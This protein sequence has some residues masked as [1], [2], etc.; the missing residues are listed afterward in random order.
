[1]AAE[2]R[3]GSREAC[4]QAQAMIDI[5]FEHLN[6]LRT[7]CLA[8]NHITQNEIRILETKLVRLFARQLVARQQLERSEDP[9]EYPKLQMWLRVVGLSEPSIAGVSRLVGGSFDQLLA[10][11]DDQIKDVLCDQTEERLRLLTALRN[12][13]K[14]TSRQLSGTTQTFEDG[15][16]DLSWEY[17][18]CPEGLTIESRLGASM[19]SGSSCSSSSSYAGTIDG[20]AT[21]GEKAAITGGTGSG[22]AMNTAGT[23]SAAGTPGGSPAT[24]NNS[25]GVSGLAGSGAGPQAI[26]T[27]PASPGS[28][29]V[30][31]LV[32]QSGN[33]AGNATTASSVGSVTSNNMTPHVNNSANSTAVNATA[34]VSPVE[35]LVNPTALTASG[36][37]A[38]SASAGPCQHSRTPP[39]IRK[40]PTSF[41]TSLNNNNNAAE[42]SGS[43]GLVSKSRSHEHSLRDHQLEFQQPPY[44]HLQPQIQHHSC[45]SS[46]NSVSGSSNQP[47][48]L[49][50]QPQQQQQ[51]QQQFSQ[52]IVGGPS[53]IGRCPPRRR[54]QTEPTP[55]SGS[56]SPSR[57]PSF[58]TS[59]DASADNAFVESP[60]AP[61]LAGPHGQQQPASVPTLAVPRSPRLPGM[62]HA[63]HHRFSS[64]VKVTTCQQCDK[65]MF[66]G[67]KCR[68]CKFRC[69]RDCVDKVPPSCGLPNELVDVFAQRYNQGAGSEQ[70]SSSPLPGHSPSL[71]RHVLSR[72]GLPGGVGPH[73]SSA[74][75]P[76]TGDSSSNTSSCNSSAPNSP[77]V[78]ASV[79]GVSGKQVFRFPPD[80]LV[81]AA[82]GRD[83][84]LPSTSGQGHAGK[85][86]SLR[87]TDSDRTVVSAASNSGSISTDSEKTLSLRIGSQD[88]QV[89]FDVAE[90]DAAGKPWPRQNS[91]SLRE[92]D[93]PLDEVQLQEKLGEGR[94]GVVYRGSWHGAVAVKMLNMEQASQSASRQSEIMD[95]FK[96]EVATFRKTRHENLV[97]FMGACMKPPQLAIVTSLCKGMTLYRHL[98][99]RKDKF[100]LNR[101]SQIA[102]QI[103]HGMGYL[104]A[105]GILHKDLKTKNIFYEN[106]KVVIT[107]FG[108]FSVVKLCQGGQGGHRGDW[109]TIP[110]GWLC[111]LAPELI[112][113]LRPGAG[114]PDLSFSTRSDVYAFGTVFYELLCG[115]WPFRSQPPEAIIWQVA[116]GVKPPLAN[117]QT[118]QDVKDILMSCWSFQADDRPDFARLQMLLVRLPKKRLARCPSH[119]VHLSRSAESVF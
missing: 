78:L 114:Q 98:H 102:L 75:G 16:E 99:L 56:L 29:L 89:S 45:T 63:I 85:A 61:G 23:G 20:T 36:N 91:L 67:Y 27:Q 107:D 95:T 38:S 33:S 47:L 22:I 5:S 53:G 118:S 68:E 49:Q 86:N 84:S 72:Q 59:P 119:P 28:P 100:N 65:P 108:L 4:L 52:H 34:G 71:P 113:D 77:Q 3:Y 46:T 1:M 35:K 14:C 54:H 60:D 21:S 48:Q 83:G 81:A 41:V 112:R 82:S 43:S 19:A 42:R 62:G 74:Y 94:F 15:F 55:A 110:Q 9:F 7:T 32:S 88:S 69:H 11:S 70:V 13:R 31:H 80:D 58:I 111:Y 39:Y 66:F 104:H 73:F 37:A 109:L 18:T 30:N 79:G 117:L 24:V 96:Q 6:G 12:L 106:G 97:L 8:D 10:R 92:W 93:I 2:E 90:Q 26:L 103:C 50:T 51:Q 101:I 115:D 116:K 40:T 25:S 44:P 17:L 64:T 76:Q 105:R 87:S 57:S